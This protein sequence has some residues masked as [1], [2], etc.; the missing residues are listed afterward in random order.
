MTSL[1]DQVVKVAAGF[2]PILLP[3]S[4]GLALHVSGLGEGMVAALRYF[5]AL[6][7]I[8]CPILHL[9]LSSTSDFSNQAAAT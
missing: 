1:T 8:T 4:D 7:S 6:I 9:I 2:P 5:S 3:L